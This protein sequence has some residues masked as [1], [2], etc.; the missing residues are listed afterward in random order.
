MVV[1]SEPLRPEV[2]RRLA[3]RNAL[4]SYEAAAGL[5]LHGRSRPSEAAIDFL[6]T[7][8]AQKLERFFDKVVD[9][10]LREW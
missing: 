8:A 7:P 3:Y 9:G 5:I 10:L 2:R 1:L 6:P 4:E